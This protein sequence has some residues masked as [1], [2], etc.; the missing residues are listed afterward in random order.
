MRKNEQ[1]SQSVSKGKGATHLKMTEKIKAAHDIYFKNCQHS[2]KINIC[3]IHLH[4]FMPFINHIS[5]KE[6]CVNI[7]NRITI[8]TLII[9]NTINMIR[10]EEVAGVGLNIHAY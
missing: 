10:W 8:D 2:S 3:N 1:I 9:I 4:I 7:V 5:N 6:I